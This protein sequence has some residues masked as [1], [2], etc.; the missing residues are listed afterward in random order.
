LKLEQAELSETAAALELVRRK[1]AELEKD[2]AAFGAFV[3]AGHDQV[4]WTVSWVGSMPEPAEFPTESTVELQGKIEAA[5]TAASKLEVLPAVDEAKL[6]ELKRTVATLC[7]PPPAAMKSAL[8]S[9]LQS[10]Q[11][12]QAQLEVTKEVSDQEIETVK[13]QIAALAVADVAAARAKETDTVAR[14]NACRAQI[15]GAAQREAVRVSAIA[16]LK[17]DVTGI[18]KTVETVR[19][20]NV[21][22]KEFRA[23]RLKVT[24]LLWTKVLGGTSNYFSRM[25]NEP[26]IVAR[27]PKG[28]T[29]NGGKVVSGSTMDILGLALRITVVKMFSSCG[30]MICDEANAGADVNRSAAMTATVSGAGFDQVFLITHKDVDE[31]GCDHLIEL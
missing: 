24:D 8:Q 17:A 2:L 25:R 31:S 9:E 3:E 26:S 28:F 5:K 14:L 21:F 4:P 1:Q 18:E 15:D 12:A 13:A 10:A 11:K 6:A 23:A 30:I 20:N 19:E 7:A 29:I 27:T 16:R 22:L